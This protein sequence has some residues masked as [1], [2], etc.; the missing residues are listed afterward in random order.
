MECIIKFMDTVSTF[1]N[2]T[3]KTIASLKED[4]KSIR[5][6]R[7]SP[8][9][10]ENLTVETY[11]GTTK[12]RLLE[13]ATIMTEGASSISISPY[14]PSVIQ[15][16][17]KAIL[18]SPLGLT[19]TTLGAKIVIRIP[20]LNTEQREKYIKV[21]AEKVEE[22]KV[23]IRNHRDDSR[24]TIKNAF[25]KKEMSEDEKYRL[26]KEIDAQSIKFMEEINIIK[27][28]KEKE[29]MEV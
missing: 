15:D 16:I 22:K 3:L 28:S 4:L 14:D 25:E 1:S 7:A 11:G 26:E 8:S 10:V 13:L 21:V 19:P 17:E 18:K 9:L 29:I 2:Q 20:S 24:K 6:G 12:L 23:T 27:E 5:T